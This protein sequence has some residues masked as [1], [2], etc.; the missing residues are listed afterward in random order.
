[1]IALNAR[2][3]PVPTLEQTSNSRPNGNRGSS[4]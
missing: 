2:I 4:L 1:M 3:S